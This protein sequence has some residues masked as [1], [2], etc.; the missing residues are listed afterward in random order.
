MKKIIFVGASIPNLY[1]A[2]ELKKKGYNVIIYE[3]RGT[4]NNPQQRRLPTTFLKKL[5][6]PIEIND[7]YIYIKLSDLKNYLSIGINI[8][9]NSN[10]NID[11]NNE[12]IMF[13]NEKIEFDFAILNTGHNEIKHNSNKIFTYNYSLENVNNHFAGNSLITSIEKIKNILSKIIT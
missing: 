1:G 10:L 4:Y 3:K 2:T 12:I 7:E 13:G 8:V 11:L 9:Y 6:L 5:G